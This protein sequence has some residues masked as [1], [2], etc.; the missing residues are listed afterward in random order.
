MLELV[1]EIVDCCGELA[2]GVCLLGVSS[3]YRE[4][5]CV[6]E[7]GREWIVDEGGRTGW[8]EGEVTVSEVGRD[9]VSSAIAVV[10][11]R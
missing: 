7:A 3:V 6:C 5:E 11:R 8:L 4:R 2:L 9:L 10:D 1:E